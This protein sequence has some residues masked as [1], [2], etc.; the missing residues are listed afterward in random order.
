[1]KI[2]RIASLMLVC[3][4]SL[5]LFACTSQEQGEDLPLDGNEKI[6]DTQSD[7][8][9]ADTR[10]TTDDTSSEDEG[11]AILTAP[12]IPSEEDI[13]RVFAHASE[14]WDRIHISSLDAIGDDAPGGP[15]SVIYDGMQYYPVRD[16]ETKADLEIRFRECFS[17]GLTEHQLGHMFE[18][19]YREINGRLYVAQADRGTDN[20]ASVGNIEYEVINDTKIKVTR[21]IDVKEST[22]IEGYNDM[23]YAAG[24]SPQEMMLIY[25]DGRWVFDNFFVCD[26]L[27]AYDSGE[28][29]YYEYAKEIAT[30]FVKAEALAAHFT[31]HASAY[32][33]GD[34]FEAVDENGFT[35]Y[36]T[37]YGLA[38]SLTEL[39]AMLSEV[40]TEQAAD[41]LMNTKVSGLPLFTERD[42]KLYKFGGYVGLL[43]YDD[44]YREIIGY[45][46][47]TDGSISVTVHLRKSFNERTVS[48]NQTYTAVLCEDGKYRFDGLSPLPIQ[49]VQNVELT[50]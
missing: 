4:L 6:D 30:V 16:Y 27:S 17:K 10:D 44:V 45:T 1:M 2:Y 26:S 12:A 19:Q 5:S 28:G 40:F 7:T 43:G 21:Y 25:E 13:M 31:G 41:K 20:R 3:L 29:V 33:G 50:P 8:E 37:P 49:I 48:A 15:H 22:Y 18:F 39:R 35:Q 36:Y 24:I 38:S 32:L 11:F 46:E 42:G 47:N 23:W 9:N 14:I 34:G